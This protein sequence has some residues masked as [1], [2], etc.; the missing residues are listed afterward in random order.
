MQDITA[1]LIGICTKDF[2]KQKIEASL[3]QKSTVIVIA[4]FRFWLFISN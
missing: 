4:A 1:A 2:A 3:L